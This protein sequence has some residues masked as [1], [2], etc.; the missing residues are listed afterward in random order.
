MPPTA[1]PAAPRSRSGSTLSIDADG[2]L[3]NSAGGLTLGDA[4]TSGTLAVTATLSTARGI[5]LGAGGGTV[6]TGIGNAVTFTGVIT[7]TGGLTKNGAGTLVLS[8][9]NNYTGGTTVSA[10]TV[11]LGLGGSLASTGAL[12]VNGGT[13]NLNGHTQTV[14]TL[15]GTGGTVFL[16]SGALTVTQGADVGYAGVI[17]GTGSLT[18]TGAGTLTLTG[19]NDYGGGTTVS[20]GTLAGTTDSLQGAILDNA[21]VT[22]DQD[23]NGNYSGALTGGGG[24]TKNGSGTVTLLGSNTYSGGTIVNGGTL[25]GTTVTLQ[26]DIFDNANVTFDQSTTGTYSDTISGSGSVTKAGS[27]TVTLLGDN[28]YTGGTIITGGSLHGTTVSLQGDIHLDAADA[29]V[30]FDQTVAGSYTKNIT[31][32]GSLTKDGAGTLTL[33]GDNGYTGGTTVSGGT[34]EGTTVSLDGD[35]S[36]AAGAHVAFDQTAAGVFDGDVT[37][38]GSLIKDG[39][40]TVTLTGDNN[41]G[42]GTEVDAGILKGT[43]S[44]LQGDIF[45]AGGADVAFDQATAGSYSGVLSGNGQLIKSGAGILTLDGHQQLPGRHGGDGGRAQHLQRCQSGERRHGDDGCGH[46]P[47]LHRR[48]DL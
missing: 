1:I 32:S 8:G 7:G 20:A 19:A 25:A 10:G 33:L 29:N 4:T 16:G 21:N 24:L 35:I 43:T 45:A 42:G 40:G 6:A 23:T 18:K 27:G 46:Q 9:A 28:G 30:T 41:Y 2:A 3:G 39:I 47:R 31:G 44:S 38:G 5:T 13:F 37:G 34:L 17:T 36:V 26:G 22:F 12:T 14:G 48:G 11:Q 15:S